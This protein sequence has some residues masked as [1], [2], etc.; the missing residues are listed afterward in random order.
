MKSADPADGGASDTSATSDAT[1]LDAASHGDA[2]S[3]SGLAEAA[4]H[5]AEAGAVDAAKATQ[6]ILLLFGDDALPARGG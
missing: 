1:S 6:G 2:G 4:S 5:D 3:S